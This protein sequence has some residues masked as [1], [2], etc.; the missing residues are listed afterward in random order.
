[1]QKICFFLYQFWAIFAQTDAP[2]MPFMLDELKSMCFKL[3]DLIFQ[4]GVI[5]NAWKIS[6]KLKRVC[7]L[8][9]KNLLDISHIDLGVATQSLLKG[10]QVALEKKSIFWYECQNIVKNIIIFI[11]YW[12]TS[13]AILICIMLYIIGFQTFFRK[14][15]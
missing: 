2:V 3:F 12:K 8:D 1:M 5:G 15:W 13:P 9:E 4:K 14:L 10:T 7:I 11:I 6:S